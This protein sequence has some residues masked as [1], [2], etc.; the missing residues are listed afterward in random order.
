MGPV[1]SA[2]GW[3]VLF[4]CGY[5]FGLKCLQIDIIHDIA[6][7]FSLVSVDYSLRIGHIA[8]HLFQS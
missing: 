5:R 7:T 1:V 8:S 6:V 3:R 4:G 2:F